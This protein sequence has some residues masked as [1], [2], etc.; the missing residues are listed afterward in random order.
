MTISFT[1]EY[2]YQC[3]QLL[4]RNEHDLLP[5]L[6]NTYFEQAQD[7]GCGFARGISS[8]GL[9]VVAPAGVFYHVTMA[10]LCALE[11]F[12]NDDQALSERAWTHL[13]AAV[14]DV[15]GWI[16]AS[17]S[18]LIAGVFALFTAILILIDVEAG[19]L[20]L[21][22]AGTIFGISIC[23]GSLLPWILPY[24]AAVNGFK[25]LD[26]CLNPTEKAQYQTRFIYEKLTKAGWANPGV[27]LSAAQETELLAFYAK[28]PYSSTE[29]HPV[30]FG[31][32]GFARLLLQPTWN[33]AA[34]AA[35]AALQKWRDKEPEMRAAWE[36][37][38]AASLQVDVDK[39][40]AFLDREFEPKMREIFQA[41]PAPPE[42]VE[43]KE[44]S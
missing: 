14:M 7:V 18:L 36:V 24:H 40:E 42:E 26:F 4:S 6:E 5:T 15:D 35:Q 32:C 34:P 43:H 41:Q 9:I 20:L 22:Y 17:S 37:V 39:R 44:V 30:A 28:I 21:A 38:R 19:I 12:W 1:A 11:G 10:V 2:L 13:G 8:F 25:F 23:N 29:L 27:V 3:S 31:K 33:H 16:E